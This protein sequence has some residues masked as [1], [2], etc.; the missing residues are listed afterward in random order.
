M[1][2]KEVENQKRISVRE[3]GAVSWGTC[4]EKGSSEKEIATISTCSGRGKKNERWVREGKNR[5]R[6]GKI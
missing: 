1:W 2:Q 3:E 4:S 5:G 6:G